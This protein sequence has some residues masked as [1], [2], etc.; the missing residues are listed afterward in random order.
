M[1][2]AQTLNENHMMTLSQT[3]N[4][5]CLRISVTRLIPMHIIMRVST[6]LK[7]SGNY[8]ITLINIQLTE[9]LRFQ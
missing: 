2:E 5:R 3:L 4:T 7:D 6:K 9:C 1:T 8:W